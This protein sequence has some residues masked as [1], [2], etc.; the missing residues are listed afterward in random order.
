MK[1]CIWWSCTITGD[2]RVDIFNEK[3][4]ETWFSSLEETDEI[5]T[6]ESTDGD[7]DT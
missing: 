4:I 3:R 5:S 6:G 2:P 1:R 7:S